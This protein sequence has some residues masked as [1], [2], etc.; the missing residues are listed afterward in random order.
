MSSRRAAEEL[1]DSL[2]INHSQYHLG[3]TKVT[4]TLQRMHLEKSGR[5]ECVSES[6][7]GSS[8]IRHAT[9]LRPQIIQMELS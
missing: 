7:Y 6:T 1:F 8:I 3:I 5:K 4:G 9:A 2:E